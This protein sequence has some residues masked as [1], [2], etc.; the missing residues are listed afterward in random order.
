MPIHFWEV[1]IA[2]PEVRRSVREALERKFGGVID[3]FTITIRE[4]RSGDKW[5]LKVDGPLGE[6]SHTLYRD[7]SEHQPDNVAAAVEPMLKQLRAPQREQVDSN[8]PKR[9]R[10]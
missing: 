2:D 9:L 1:E 3:H 4:S 7:R 8:Q 10:R 5:E 6:R